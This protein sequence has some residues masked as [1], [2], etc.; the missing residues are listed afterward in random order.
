MPMLCQQ[1][2]PALPLLDKNSAAA[3]VMPKAP[4][5]RFLTGAMRRMPYRSVSINVRWLHLNAASVWT[6]NVLQDLTRGA[7]GSLCWVREPH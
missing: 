6:K 7:F 1:Q 3:P 4:K 5:R 2:Q